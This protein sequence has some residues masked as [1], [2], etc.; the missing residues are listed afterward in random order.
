MYNAKFFILIVHFTVDYLHFIYLHFLSLHNYVL[1][2]SKTGYGSRL[3]T[4]IYS[5]QASWALVR[6]NDSQAISLKCTASY[7]YCVVVN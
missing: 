1:L 2:V 7:I 4:F 3:G 5:P 6:L